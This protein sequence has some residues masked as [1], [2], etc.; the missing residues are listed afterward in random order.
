M[1]IL[2]NDRGTNL[3][4]IEKELHRLHDELPTLQKERELAIASL[5]TLEETWNNKYPVFSK[6]QLDYDR[7]K[8]KLDEALIYFA[9]ILLGTCLM[10][11]VVLWFIGGGWV[12]FFSILALA[13]G[14]IVRGLVLSQLRYRVSEHFPEIDRIQQEYATTKSKLQELTTREGE[15]RGKIA[16]F[17][18]A[19]LEQEMKE[20]GLFK[21]IDRNRNIRYGTPEQLKKWRAIDID[22]G[23]NFKGLA[24]REFESL[25][26]D[27]FEKMGYRTQLTPYV[28]DYG[29]D[30]IARKDEDI[31]VIEVK[32][33]QTT[34]VGSPEVQKLLGSLFKY[35]AKKAIFVTTSEFTEQAKEIERNAPLELWNSQKLNNMLEKYFIDDEST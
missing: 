9:G 19:K 14:Y 24:P 3:S 16:S 12:V 8:G 31:I 29:A 20:K 17:A 7:M 15:I 28:G 5:D 30:V 13:V 6:L 4:Q 25:I 35:K 2:E 27:L 23:N 32:K 22:M 18:E 11:G 33:W 26:R 34:M 21:F 10:F 1:S